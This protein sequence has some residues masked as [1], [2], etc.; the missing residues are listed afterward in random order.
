[1]QIFGTKESGFWKPEKTW[2]HS[3]STDEV[4]LL[5]KKFVSSDTSALKP[6]C[7]FA[8]I[9]YGGSKELALDDKSPCPEIKLVDFAHVFEG[10]ALSIITS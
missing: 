3:I 6:D 5:L 10:E 1:M 8:S 7:A 9:V 2:I 4:R